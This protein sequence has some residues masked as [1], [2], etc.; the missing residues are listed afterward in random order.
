MTTVERLKIPRAIAGRLWNY[1]PEPRAWR[2]RMHRHAELE[3]NLVVRGGARYVVEGA[4]CDLTPGSLIWLL[5]AQDHLL[6]SQSDDLE[7]WIA[8]FRPSLVRDACRGR[9]YRPLRSRRPTF[10]PHRLLGVGA[11]GRLRRLLSECNGVGSDADRFN[12]GLRHVL[13][14]AWAAHRAA[15]EA[16]PLPD[17]HPGVARAAMLIRDVAEPLNIEQIA[18]RAGLSPSQLSRL[19]HRQTGLTLTRFRQRVCLERFFVLLE[20]GESNLMRAA[21]QAGFGSYAQFHRV[22]VA[23]TGRSPRAV[24]RSRVGQ[25]VTA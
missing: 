6:V 12:A 23:A 17:L 21:L 2:R 4:L 18:D 7:M 16:P 14:E 22:F 1:R 24:A 15:G 8:V 20:R 3:L 13:V 11:V 25:G 9:A 19:F 10:Q 5:P